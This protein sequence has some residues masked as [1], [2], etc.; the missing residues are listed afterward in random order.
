[1][2]ICEENNMLESKEDKLDFRAERK[3]TEKNATEVLKKKLFFF[4]FFLN[5]KKASLVA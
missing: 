3:I 2:V 1:M 5:I 4:F